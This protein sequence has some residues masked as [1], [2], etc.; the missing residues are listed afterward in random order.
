[1]NDKPISVGDLVVIVKSCCDHKL[2]LV[3]RVESFY[4]GN[5]YKGDVLRCDVCAKNVTPS[6][7]LT[8]L[9][10]GGAWPLKWLKKI[11][12]PALPQDVEHDE[13]IPA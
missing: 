9:F 5:P 12:P 4:R 13:E 10:G 8:A 11:D 6:D 1:M 2:G 7:M 3:G